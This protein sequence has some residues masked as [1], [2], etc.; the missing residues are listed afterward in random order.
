MVVHDRVKAPKARNKV[1]RGKRVSRDAPGSSVNQHNADPRWV[2]VL[3][4]APSGRDC[5]RVIQ[6]WRPDF[7]GTYP[8]LLYVTPSALGPP[9]NA[10]GSDKCTSDVR[11][12]SARVN[13]TTKTLDIGRWTILTVRSVRDTLSKE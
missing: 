9:A 2:G 8:W 11:A 4:C 6:G 3:S 5:E 13:L 10:G 7:I 1:A 12:K